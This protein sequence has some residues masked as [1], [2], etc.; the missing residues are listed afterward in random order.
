[1]K[2]IRKIISVL[3][4]FAFIASI[5]GCSLSLSENEG[6]KKKIEYGSITIKGGNSEGDSR[7][8]DVSTITSATVTVSGYGMTD[9]TKTNVSIAAGQGNA[10]IENIPTGSNRVVTVES[11]VSGATIRAVCDVNSGENPVSV[12]WS[13]TAVGNVFYSLIKS[14]RDVSEIAKTAFNSAIDG[15]VH[16]SLIDAATIAS[17]Y[18]SL[19]AASAYVSDYGTVSVTTSA[20]AGYSVQITDIASEKKSISGA[21]DSFE[22]KAYPGSWKAWVLDAEGNKVAEKDITVVAGET[23]TVDVKYS[24][25]SNVTGKIVVHVPSSLGY[26]NIWAWATSG[27]TNY[28]GG[29]WPGKEMTLN[30]SNYDYTIE[31]TACK[32]IFNNNGGSNVGTNQTNDLWITEGEWN[33]IGGKAGTED[34]TGSSVASNFEEVP[35]EP[36][37]T[38]TVNSATPHGEAVKIYVSSTSG[39]PTIWA[40]TS[41]YPNI[42]TAAGYPGPTMVAATDLNDNTGW[43]VAEMDTDKIDTNNTESI[44]FILNSGSNIVSTKT[45]TFWYDAAGICGAAGT[46]YD[47]DPTTVPEPVLPT[48]KIRPANGNEIPV[49]GSIQVTLT[50]GNDTISSASVTLSGDVSRTYTYSDFNG[51]SLSLSISSLGLSVGDSVTVSASVTNSVGSASDSSSL[52]VKEEAQEDPFT[53]DN[54]NVY[55]VIQDRFYDGDSSNNNSYG[56]MSTDELGKNIGT[57]HG[58]DIKGLTQKLDYLNDLGVNAVWITAPYE[59]AHGWCGGGSNG[60]FAHYAYHGYYPLDYTMI[61]KNMG[62]VEEFRTFVTECHRRGIRVVMDVVMNHTGYLTLQDCQDYNLDIFTAS[63]TGGKSTDMGFKIG[64]DGD[65]YHAHHSKIDYDG[66]NSGWANWWGNSWVRAGVP[67]YTAGGN[68][69]LTKNLD[70]LPDVKSE[71]TT[72][73]TVAPILA[74]KWAQ[75]TSG[76]DNWIIPAAQSLRSTSATNAPVVWI[77]KWLAAWVEEFGIDG[78]RCD[79]AKHV[80]KYRWGELKNL[81]KTALAAW[82]QSNRADQYAKDW[83][84]DFWMTGECFGWGYGGDS[85]WFSNGF[86]TMIDFSA[87]G[88]SFGSLPQWSNRT[89]NRQGLLYISSHDTSLGRGS[90]QKEIGTQFVLMPGPI[91]IFYGDETCRAFGDTGSD[92][93]QGTRSDFNWDAA[94]GDCAKHWAKLGTFRKFN[95]AVGAGSISGNTRTYEDNQV[96]ISVDGT[97]VSVPYANGTT[98]YN[99]YDGASAIVS[100][101]SVTFAGGSMTQPILV[102]DKN[103]ATYGITF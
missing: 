44:S 70:N 16:A 25:G 58:G 69:D 17:D 49:N 41:T 18:P 10:T 12:N 78:F 59:Q 42:T 62:T 36:G 46:Y 83:D 28:T 101:G 75:E 73:Q 88:G 63:Y 103:P 72:A 60:D 97:S 21:S 45:T 47:S 26:K 74:T 81:C 20:A 87:N 90:N 38:L 11:N 8:L 29:N 86:D 80:D 91:Q 27:S 48:V 95:P 32:I 2:K 66:H 93:T 13:T 37:I 71:N 35:S 99:W 61:D 67:G 92:P 39:A 50:D 23:S 76:Y 22:L 33:Y 102:S 19:K 14:G 4:T 9:I 53:W 79:T 77:E 43:Y 15:T 6:G 65:N 1:M 51:N 3:A 52:T 94:N 7:A 30:G 56:R 54:A 24:A 31:Q 100:D 98:V 89:G 40:W 64:N 5:A 85:S 84:E 57:F 68:D 55:F 34:T 96:V 82:R